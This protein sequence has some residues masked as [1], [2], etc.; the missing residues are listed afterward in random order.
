MQETKLELNIKQEVSLSITLMIFSALLS[1]SAVIGFVLPKSHS[2]LPQE[3][4]ETDDRVS[5]R[6]R[7]HFT[8][9]ASQKYCAFAYETHFLKCVTFHRKS[10]INGILKNKGP[11]QQSPILR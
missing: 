3:L 4:S 11:Q 6:R 5:S 9:H 2:N 8:A 10:N 1:V 7:K